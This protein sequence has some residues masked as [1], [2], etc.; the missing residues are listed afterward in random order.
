MEKI[1]VRWSDRKSKGTTSLVRKSAVKKGR[2][3][4]GEKVVVSWGKSKKNFNAEGI[5]V[6]G[7]QAFPSA[8]TGVSNYVGERNEVRD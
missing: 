6:N 3:V 8:T 5:D 4:V 7:A 1:L 2:I